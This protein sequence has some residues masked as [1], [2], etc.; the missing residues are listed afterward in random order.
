[1]HLNFD[2]SF[3]LILFPGNAI[4]TNAHDRSSGNVPLNVIPEANMLTID[5]RDTNTCTSSDN[6][7][8]VF[9]KSTLLFYGS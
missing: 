9:C 3:P 4:V 8:G 5:L 1:M 7:P 6:S 2:R